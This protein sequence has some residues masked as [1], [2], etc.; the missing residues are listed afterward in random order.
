MDPNQTFK[1]MIELSNQIIVNEDTQTEAAITLAYNFLALKSWFPFYSMGEQVNNNKN[2]AYTLM[3]PNGIS[4]K[5]W[6]IA[7]HIDPLTLTQAKRKEVIQD[8]QN[9]VNTSEYLV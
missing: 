7:A 9:G 6:C 1:K 3:N 8:W 4:Y 5:R 2:H